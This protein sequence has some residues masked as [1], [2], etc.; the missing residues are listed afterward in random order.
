MLTTVEHL[1]EVEPVGDL[2]LKGFHRPITAFNV[3]RIKE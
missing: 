2:T 1:I 3:L